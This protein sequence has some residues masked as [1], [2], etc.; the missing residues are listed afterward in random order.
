MV[1]NG[2]TA[3]KQSIVE[4]GAQ[5]NATILSD[6]QSRNGSDSNILL[7]TTSKRAAPKTARNGSFNLGDNHFSQ[8]LSG[9][10]GARRPGSLAFN[11][12]TYQRNSNALSLIQNDIATGRSKYQHSTSCHSLTNNKLPFRR[13]WKHPT[14]ASL[15]ARVGQARQQS[16]RFRSGFQCEQPNLKSGQLGSECPTNSIAERLEQVASQCDSRG[17]SHFPHR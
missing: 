1:R 13:D 7:T 14:A 15:G 8:P 5:I 2:S 16:A 6:T 17:Q 11:R 10:K 12:S 3:L 9:K 4:N